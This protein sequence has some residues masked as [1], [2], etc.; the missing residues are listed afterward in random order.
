MP[1]NLSYLRMWTSRTGSY[2]G[3]TG[4]SCQVRSE[5]LCRK[6]CGTD[7][8]ASSKWPEVEAWK[9]MPRLRPLADLATVHQAAANVEP[10]MR[11][12]GTKVWSLMQL[13]H[14]LR[15]RPMGGSGAAL[16]PVA[17]SEPRT[18]ERHDRQMFSS[19]VP[20]S[21]PPPRLLRRTVRADVSVASYARGALSAR[22]IGPLR[23]SRRDHP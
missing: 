9:E 11:V 12:D 22:V 7:G 23:G 19:P 21:A 18:P 5:D 13:E 15:L 3:H 14:Q 1:I 10:Y 20:V 2:R 4:P 17:E 6:R 16:S 8:D